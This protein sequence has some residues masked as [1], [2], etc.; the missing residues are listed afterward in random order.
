[1]ELDH[2]SNGVLSI[3]EIKRGLKKSKNKSITKEIIS[4]FD[5]IDTD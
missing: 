1:M 3:E 2:D 4:T 5:S